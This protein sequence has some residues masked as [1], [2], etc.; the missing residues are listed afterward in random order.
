MHTYRGIKQHTA[1]LT[2]FTAVEAVRHTAAIKHG[3]D[4]DE[5]QKAAGS[6]AFS[7]Y[8]VEF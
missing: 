3:P 1:H 4:S 6:L 8:S 2:A 7:V 5:D